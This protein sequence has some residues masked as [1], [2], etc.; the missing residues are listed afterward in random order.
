M[1]HRYQLR[2]EQAADALAALGSVTRLR[3]FKVL[4]RAGGEGANIGSIQKLLDV[5]PTTLAHH[6]AALAAAGLIHQE[7]RGRAVICTAN[8][9]RL[10]DMLAYLKAECCAGIDHATA[11]AAVAL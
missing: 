4:V 11:D 3:V 5:P 10:N 1:K 9:G 7:R 2:D 8:Y 6:L